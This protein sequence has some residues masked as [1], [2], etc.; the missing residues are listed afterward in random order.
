[1]LVHYQFKHRAEGN[2]QWD[3]LS[4]HVALYGLL[5]VLSSA[6]IELIKLY[7]WNVGRKDYDGFPNYWIPVMVMAVALPS[8]ARKLPG[9]GQ[10]CHGH[11]HDHSYAGPRRQEN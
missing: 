11:G 4:S 8:M 10:A 7:P 2:L 1:M 3:K 6:D 5:T 9:H